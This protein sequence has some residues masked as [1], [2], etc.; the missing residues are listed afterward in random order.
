MSTVLD[1]PPSAPLLEVVNTVAA[2]GA[3]V[4]LPDLTT[5]QMHAITLTAACTLTFPPI[6]AGK[7]IYISLKQ[8]ATGSRLVTWP[9]TVKWA[10]G[11]APTL[12][13]IAGRTDAFSFWTVD[14]ATWHGLTIGINLS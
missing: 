14:G 7:S 10:G 2:S 8:D 11:T 3:A 12:S 6:V 9:A 5:A 13:T 4:T 1:Y